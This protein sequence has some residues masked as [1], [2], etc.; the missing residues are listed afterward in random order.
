MKKYQPAHRP[1]KSKTKE[2]RELIHALQT[3]QVDAIVGQRHVMLVRL[4]QV[5]EHLKSSRDQLRALAG[6]CCRYARMNGR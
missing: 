6:I 1:S 5:E 3:H 2:T 4:K